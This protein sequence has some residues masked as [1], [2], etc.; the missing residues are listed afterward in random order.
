MVDMDVVNDDIADKLQGDAATTHNVDVSS[1]AIQCLVAVED[2][3][4]GKLDEHVSREDDPQGLCL[5]HGVPQGSRLRVHSVVVG[6]V[7]DD[8]VF[9]VLAAESVLSEADG[10]VSEALA[11]V[12]PLRVAF[13]TVVDGV[14]CKARG[15]DFFSCLQHLPSAYGSVYSPIKKKK[16][17]NAK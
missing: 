14:S 11:V 3:L 2:E 6:V 12:G 9:A 7:G 1:A 5:Y 17:I 8:V 4:L 16:N 15:V 13:P 10:A